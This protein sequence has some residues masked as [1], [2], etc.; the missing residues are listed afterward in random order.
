VFGLISSVTTTVTTVASLALGATL[1]VLASI[2][3]I[4]L[5]SAKEV[6]AADVSSPLTALGRNLNVAILPLLLVFTLIVTFKVLE[7][8]A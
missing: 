2:L 5:L 1:G 6:A 8:I 7:V 4:L 3:L